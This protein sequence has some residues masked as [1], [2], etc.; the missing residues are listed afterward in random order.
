MGSDRN[1]VNLLDASVLLGEIISNIPDRPGYLFKPIKGKWEI[2]DEI[3]ERLA[4]GAIKNPILKVYDPETFFP[5]PAH[6]IQWASELIVDS[7]LL[8]VESLNS[9][10]ESEGIPV[11]LG[12]ERSVHI[13]NSFHQHDKNKAISQFSINEPTRRNDW[14]DCIRD[15]AISFYNN[16]GKLPSE[17][18]LWAMLFESSLPEWSLST[19]SRKGLIALA[20]KSLDREAFRKRYRDYF[21]DTNGE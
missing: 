3:H 14:F 4:R 13:L 1:F 21:S 20:G 8:S 15:H 7:L 5:I 17:S 12:D 6:E 10:L 2:A 18:Q 16:Y 11:K 9:W 19:D